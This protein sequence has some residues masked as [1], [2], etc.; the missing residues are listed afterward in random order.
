MTIEKLTTSASLKQVMDKFEEIKFSSFFN[1]NITTSNS[2]PDTGVEGQ[3]HIVTKHDPNNI[4]MEQDKPSLKE[5]DIF[6]KIETKTPYREFK[7]SATGRTITTRCR[8]IIQIQNDKEVVLYGYIR[9]NQ[10]WVS[11][12]DLKLDVFLEGTGDITAITGGYNIYTYSKYQENKE[13]VTIDTSCIKVNTKATSNSSYGSY[14]NVV[15]K[16]GIDVTSYS[17]LKVQASFGYTMPSNAQ[18]FCK[19]GITTS[20]STTDNSF[21]LKDSFTYKAGSLEVHSRKIFEFDVSDLMGEFYFK[22]MAESTY[23]STETTIHN[24]WLEK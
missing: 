22:A 1:L 21:I 2:L 6:V 7:L 12:I 4:Y 9:I 3:L 18:G 14:A 5:K 16:R 17:K 11:L 8:N 19:F 13:S 15:S 23:G 24:I 10:K 20:S